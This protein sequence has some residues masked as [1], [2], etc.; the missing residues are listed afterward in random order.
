[1][2][3]VTK[4]PRTRNGHDMIWVVVDHFTKSAHFIVA[5]EK[6]SMDKLANSYVKEIVRLHGVPLTIVSDRDSRFTSRF[7]RSLQE[8]LGTKLCLSTAYHPQTDGQ[9]ERTIQTLEDM[10]RACTLEFQGNW[11]EHLPLVEFSYNNSFH[12]SIK[13]APY[14]ALYGE[15]C[16]TP[17]CWLE[18]G[19]KQF[20]GPEIV[21]ETAEK[22]KVI[23]ERMLAAQDRQKSYADKK[24]RPISFDVGDSVLLKVSSWKGLIRFGKR[25]KLSPRFIGPFKVLQRIGN[26]AYKLELPEELE[27]IHNTFHV[28]Y[29]RKF[30]GDVP[31]IIPISELRL[32]ENKRLIE[33][34]EAIVDRKT[35]KLRRKMVDLVLVRWK[36]TNGPN[37]TWETESDMMSRYPQLFGDM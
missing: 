20:M 21:H 32:D 16:R 34:P 8:E 4:L 27:G 17:S 15:K 1:M 2:D 37:L 19:E 6:W 36:H 25:G 35:M 26:Q 33:E 11:D 23:R 24:R 18:A 13:M 22:L 30:T 7:W 31:D 9:S 29:L 3:F 12:S 14:H 10:L 28:C 5:K